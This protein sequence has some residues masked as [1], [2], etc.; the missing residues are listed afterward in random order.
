MATCCVPWTEQDRFDE[1]VFR[2]GVR[3][4][5]QGTPHLY[6]FGTAGEGYA[7]TDRQFDEIVAAFADRTFHRQLAERL[8][9]WIPSG[10]IA[11]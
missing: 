8:P 2:R 11:N 5:L 10:P 6:V 7:V 4:A 3:Q 1:P 9:E